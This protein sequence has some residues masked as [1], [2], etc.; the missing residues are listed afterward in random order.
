MAV[1]HRV[2]VDVVEMPLV[3]EFV[4]NQVLPV[5]ALPDAAFAALHLGVR[6][7]FERANAFGEGEL[8]GLP[9]HREIRITRR[10]G[11]QAVHMFG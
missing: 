6:L 1:L 3:V 9:A 11:P 5:S 10:Q 4:S 8:Y 2:E 7:G